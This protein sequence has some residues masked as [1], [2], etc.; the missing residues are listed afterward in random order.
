MQIEISAILFFAHLL[1]CPIFISINFE[2]II[3]LLIQF[4]IDT[5]HVNVS[6]QLCYKLLTLLYKTLYVFMLKFSFKI[7]QYITM[8]F[9]KSLYS[10][11]NFL[12]WVILI[13]ILLSND[14]EKNPGDFSNVFLVCVIGI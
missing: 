9:K 11:D 12:L 3:S 2:L 5:S 7:I 4:E 1:L 14:V 10:W 8:L 6:L 13:I